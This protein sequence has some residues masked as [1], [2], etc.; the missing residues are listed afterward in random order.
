MYT[1]LGEMVLYVHMPRRDDSIRSHAHQKVS[2]QAFMAVPGSS[3]A[4]EG[5]TDT[6]A[7][8]DTL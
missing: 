4:E 8:W 6:N 7:G 5:W 1:C 3:Y 2:F